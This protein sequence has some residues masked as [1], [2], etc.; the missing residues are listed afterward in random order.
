MV[1]SKSSFETKIRN[2]LFV[3]Q[4]LYVYGWSAEGSECKC[5]RRE[6]GSESK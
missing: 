1:Q 5:D 6:S 3:F 2:V 4:Y